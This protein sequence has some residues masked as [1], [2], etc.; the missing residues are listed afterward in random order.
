[1]PFTLQ[2]LAGSRTPYNRLKAQAEA[3]LHHRRNNNL[4][5]STRDEGL[6]KQVH[7]CLALLVQNPRH[8]GL[9]THEY[10]SLDNPF[11][12]GQKVFEAYVQNRTPGAY[13][14]FWCYGPG[15]QEIT[16]LAI[17]PHP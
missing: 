13:R 3:S 9:Q 5:K 6:F 4:A 12:K 1:M 10:H 15:R 2:W 7:K 11:E 17:T 14:V 8:P 16:I